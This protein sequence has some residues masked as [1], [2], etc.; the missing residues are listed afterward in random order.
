MAAVPFA[1]NQRSPREGGGGKG[2]ADAQHLEHTDVAV[3][4]ALAVLR[5]LWKARLLQEALAKATVAS[6]RLYLLGMH[7]VPFNFLTCM[8][9]P[10]W[11]AERVPEGASDH[12]RVRAWREEPKSREKMFRALAAMVK[13]KM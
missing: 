4:E 12:T 7:L 1:A 2:L 13:E 5:N 10:G 6:S 3:A 8:K 11:W 9:N